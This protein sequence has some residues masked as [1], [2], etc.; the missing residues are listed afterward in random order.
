MADTKQGKKGTKSSAKGATGTGTKSGGF[1]DEE[2]AAMKERARELKA[3]SSRAEGERAVKAAIAK[4]PQP[5]RA[6]CERLH[7]VI[8]QSAPSLAP[9]TWY[10]MPAYASGDKV[11]VFFRNAEKFKERYAT[12]GFNPDAKLDEGRMWPIA[13]ALTDLTAAEEAKIAGL[14]KRAVG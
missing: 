6:M 4:M 11:V 13:F 2:K 7:G 1:S 9:R 10:G 3:S 8:T 5:G 14:V 12:L